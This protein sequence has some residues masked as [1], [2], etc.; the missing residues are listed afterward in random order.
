MYVLNLQILTMAPCCYSKD[1]DRYSTVRRTLIKMGYD[2]PMTV[3][4]LELV[5]KLTNDLLATTESLR[6]YKLLYGSS[7]EVQGSFLYQAFVYIMYFT[8]AMPFLNT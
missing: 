7:V 5:E 8:K 2:S 4:S 1:Q 6:R 3:D